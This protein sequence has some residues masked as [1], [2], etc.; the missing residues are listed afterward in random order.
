MRMIYKSGVTHSDRLASVL[1]AACLGI[2]GLLTVAWAGVL[3]LCTYNVIC[4]FVE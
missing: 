4:W 3:G 1:P 2:G